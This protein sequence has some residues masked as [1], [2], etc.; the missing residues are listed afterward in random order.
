MVRFGLMSLT[1]RL[2]LSCRFSL[3][4]VS[5]KPVYKVPLYPNTDNGPSTIN[6]DRMCPDKST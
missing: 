3:E 5:K 1:Q 4:S 2:M 6:N